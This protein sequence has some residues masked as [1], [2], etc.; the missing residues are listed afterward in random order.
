MKYAFQFSK[1]IICIK[2][3][4]LIPIKLMGQPNLDNYKVDCEAPF[5]EE[6]YTYIDRLIDTTWIDNRLIINVA[7]YDNCGYTDSKGG[8]STNGDTLILQYDYKTV[9]SVEFG[10]TVE[11]F[12]ITMCDCP[13]K[14]HFEISNLP[15]K[16]Y[17]IKLNDELLSY[18]INRFVQFPV[19]YDIKGV[20]TI[21]YSDRYGLRQ[22][23]WIDIDTIYMIKFE[24]FYKD[25]DLTNGIRYRFRNDSTVEYKETFYS[26]DSVLIEQFDINGKLIKSCYRY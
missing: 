17:L 4:L 16:K 7:K 5:D 14:F 18:S 6:K 25:D 11:V 12:F 26:S 15:K 2:I 10:D 1:R 20:D 13:L 24:G 9:T 21:N 8:F 22:G 3:I 23:F 19:K